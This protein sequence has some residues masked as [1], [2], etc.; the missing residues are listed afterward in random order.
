MDSRCMR[1][2]TF[3][4]LMYLPANLI[5]VRTSFVYPSR[6][7]K[8]PPFLLP[9][10]G[11]RLT[12]FGLSAVHLLHRLGTDPAYGDQRRPQRASGAVR[13]VGICVSECCAD[14]IDARGR[15]VLGPQERVAA[16]LWVEMRGRR[17]RWNSTRACVLSGMIRTGLVGGCEDWHDLL[18]AL[19]WEV[20]MVCYKKNTM[21]RMTLRAKRVCAGFPSIM[22]SST[23]LPTTHPSP[24]L[25]PN[26]SSHSSFTTTA[27]QIEVPKLLTSD[28]PRGSMS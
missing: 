9:E 25:Y 16:G 3:I 12:A 28:S 19:T 4:A 1:I 21:E 7:R 27:N 23:F 13:A 18:Q 14:G 11:N 24:P 10:L 2:L 5:A 20:S 6:P 15:G 26:S 17:G 8:S 22:N